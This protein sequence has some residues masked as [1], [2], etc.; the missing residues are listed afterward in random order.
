MLALDQVTFGYSTTPAY[1]FT[2]EAAAGEVT[3]FRRDAYLA[4]ARALGR[5]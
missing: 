3:A 4:V 5:G 1:E 2:M